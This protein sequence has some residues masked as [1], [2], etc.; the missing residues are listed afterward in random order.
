MCQAL[1][2]SRE[3]RYECDFSVFHS[4]GKDRNKEINMKNIRV[5]K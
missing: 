3:Y 1:P 2:W 5:I 4:S